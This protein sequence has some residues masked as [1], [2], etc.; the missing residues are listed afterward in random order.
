MCIYIYIYKYIIY[1]CC[2]R[3]KKQRLYFHPYKPVSWLLTHQDFLLRIL[4]PL[5]IC[6]INLHKNNTSIVMQ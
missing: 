5:F 2:D 3:G 1:I 4:V 6:F